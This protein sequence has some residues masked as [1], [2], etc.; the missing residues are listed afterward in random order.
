[1]TTEY[2]IKDQEQNVVGRYKHVEDRDKAF[3]KH[4]EFGFKDEVER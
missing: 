4:I 1:M 2:Q 3:D